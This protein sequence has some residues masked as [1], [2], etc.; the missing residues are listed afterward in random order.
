MAFRPFCFMTCMML[1]LLGNC[2]H[3]PPVVRHRID[4]VPS[5][6]TKRPF[7]KRHFGAWAQDR[8]STD[9]HLWIPQ[10][11]PATRK[12]TASSVISSD[13]ALVKGEN[14]SERTKAD[15]R[16]GKT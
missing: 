3:A 16:T 10:R 1:T 2:H 13:I 15:E 7:A 9:P 11:C 6:K 12:T 8:G 14:G 5:G 4:R